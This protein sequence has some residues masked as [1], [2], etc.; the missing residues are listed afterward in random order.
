MPIPSRILGSG[1]NSLLAL[2]SAGDGKD[3]IVAAG[4]TR[5]DATQIVSVYNS[6]DTVTAGTGIKLPPT[7]AGMTIFVVNSGASTLTVYPY[8][9]ATVINGGSSHSLGKD[10]TAIYFAVTNSIMY[11]ISGNKT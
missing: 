11:T 6:V 3:D 5:S 9:A 7:E 8:E 10:K 4:S 1:A 2:A